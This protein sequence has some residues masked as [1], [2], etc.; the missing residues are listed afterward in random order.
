METTK[1]KGDA[2]LQELYLLA[3]GSRVVSGDFT[4]GAGDA[5]YSLTINGAAG[6]VRNLIFKS[7]G[8]DRWRVI[9]EN[10][11]ESGSDVGSDFE[12]KSRKDD[13]SALHTVLKIIRST[14]D[15][16]LASNLTVGLDGVAEQ[17]LININSAAGQQRHLAYQSGGLDRWRVLTTGTAESGDDAGSNFII[18]SRQDNGT[19]LD[20]VLEITRASGDIQISNHL[21]VGDGSD[22]RFIRIAGGAG[23]NRTLDF[24]TGSQSRW[25]FLTNNTA[26]SGSN[27]GSDFELHARQDGGSYLSTP[28]TIV[29]STGEATFSK[30]LTVGDGTTAIATVINGVAGAVRDVR[31]A[32]NGSLRW[33]LRVD[34]TAESGSNVGSDLQIVAR[35][36]D[37]TQISVPIKI[38]RNTG[39]IKL[40]ISSDL[41]TVEWINYF[42]SSTVIGW[43]GTPGTAQIYYKKIG[44]LVFV[45]FNISGTSNLNT[46]SFTLP[47]TAAS[48]AVRTTF[49]IRDSGVYQAG[50]MAMQAGSSQ[51]IFRV[52]YGTTAAN[53]TPSGTKQLHGQFFYEA[54]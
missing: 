28:L 22:G 19:F 50:N 52:G 16:T 1:I 11:A 35:R 21:T 38:F 46:T 14:G 49:V 6:F 30:L 54:Q 5:A 25:W 15:I 43:S 23:E 37:G 7:G 41:Y 8:V 48:L 45:E 9:A 47:Y 18:Q 12:I 20:N 33:L 44:N 42:G 4:V 10:T 13:G 3:D 32:S 27:V 17:R 24:V 39:D 40:G 53:W 36:D 29:R 31:F 51:A 34:S 26:E 2:Q